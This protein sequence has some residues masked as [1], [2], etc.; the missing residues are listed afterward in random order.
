MPPKRLTEALLSHAAGELAE[1]ADEQE[2][3]DRGSVWH[4]G[5]A[6]DWLEQRM[7]VL[8]GEVF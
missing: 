7:Q 3:S 2:A 4:S 6:P 8:R 5:D 1:W